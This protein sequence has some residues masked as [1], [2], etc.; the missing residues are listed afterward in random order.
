MKIEVGVEYVIV[1]NKA[2]YHRYELGTVVKVVELIKNSK[3]VSVEDS[4]GIQHYTHIDDLELLTSIERKVDEISSDE[5]I[6]F[7]PRTDTEMLMESIMKN[8]QDRPIEDYVNIYLETSQFEAL[9]KLL[10]N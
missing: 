2:R 4:R 1:G 6:D 9:G 10:N 3:G 8:Q 5:Y 7:T